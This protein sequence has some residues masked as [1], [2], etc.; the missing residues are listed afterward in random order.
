M[1]ASLALATLLWPTSVTDHCKNIDADSIKIIGIAKDYDDKFL[2]CEVI[3][4]TNES[5]IDIDYTR[6]GKLFATKT[7]SF[8]V[9]PFAPEIA[10]FDMRSGEKREVVSA[11]DNIVLKYQ[12][13][14]NKKLQKTTIRKEDVQVIDAG[15]D[16]FMRAHWDELNSEK[17]LSIDFGSVAHQKVLPLRVSKKPVEKCAFKS[18]GSETFTC[19]WVEI[20]NALLRLVLGNIK[21]AYD[22]QH[23]LRQYEGVV[24]LQSEDQDNQKARINYFYG[25][26]YEKLVEAE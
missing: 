13:Q 8:S 26:D 16:N 2:Y 6:D 25:K 17:I 1:I 24:N 18:D 9:S 22:Q 5:Q 14:K 4:Q 10:Q 11:Q 3:R 20:D 15:F 12:A 23:R 7:V 19:F 21:I